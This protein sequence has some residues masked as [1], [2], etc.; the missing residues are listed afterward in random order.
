MKV[1]ISCE[2]GGNE[3]PAVF[4]DYFTNQ[5]T[6]LNTHRGYDMGTLDLFEALKKYSDFSKSNTV[7]RLLIE[8][9]RSINH[10]LL[11]SEFT[12]PLSAEQREILINTI[13]LPY[14]NPIETE[15]KKQIGLANTILHISLHS[16]TPQLLGEKRNNDIGLLYDSKKS[17]EKE[18]CKIWKEKLKQ[19]IPSLNVRYNY[20]YRGNA[21]G[22]TTYLRKQFP[23]HY[24]GI[25]LEMNQKWVLEAQFEKTI[26]QT[27]IKT[28]KEIIEH[29]RGSKIKIRK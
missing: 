14:R 5:I 16:F 24:I 18:F 26:K 23:H 7:S 17:A 15:I 10:P 20:P 19:E 4:K 25:E 13:Y 28:L 27:I 6:I 21:D 22:F 12:K 2:H 29:E 1:V 3:I 11:F 9:N 8:C